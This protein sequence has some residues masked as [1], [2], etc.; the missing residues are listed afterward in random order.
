[1]PLSCM[2]VDGGGV[3]TPVAVLQYALNISQRVTWYTRC[4]SACAAFKLLGSN[5]CRQVL[6]S[7][8]FLIFSLFYQL[9]HVS[10]TRF[11][12]TGLAGSV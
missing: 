11:R 6:V 9:F 7:G 10:K 8:A 5:S 2:A 1:M 4:V 12:Y 3:T